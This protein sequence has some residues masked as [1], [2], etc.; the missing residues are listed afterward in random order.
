MDWDICGNGEI[1]LHE[2]G[3]GGSNCSS[4]PIIR[5]KHLYVSFN[6]DGDSI[7]WSINGIELN[8]IPNGITHYDYPF[9]VYFG[10]N[11][12]APDGRPIVSKG[13]T[14]GSSWKTSFSTNNI[15]GSFISVGVDSTN[16]AIY[17]EQRICK[18]NGSYCFPGTTGGKTCVYDVKWGI[19][20]SETFYTVNYNA[21]GGTG[22]PDSQ[23]KSSLGALQ[24]SATV[25]TKS[26]SVQYVGVGTNSYSQRFNNWLCSADGQY[27][28]PSDWYNINSGCTMTAQ[29]GVATFT[30]PALPDSSYVVTYY[31]NGGTGSPATTTLARTKLGYNTSS[32]ATTPTYAVGIAYTTSTNLTLYPIYKNPTLVFTS[33]PKPTKAGYAFT[34]WYLDSALT[35]QVTSN[36][37]ISANTDLYA[38]WKAVPLH[39]FTSTGTWRDIPPKVYQFKNN[40]SW[41]KDRPVYR[42]DGTRWINISE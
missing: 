14:S 30:P 39:Q 35:N 25:P 31:Y 21:N 2:S 27:Y 20:P 1:S 32:S 41:V 15:S 4:K 36:I 38:G 40:N 24:L 34:G 42:F 37:V 18:H 6:R 13:W 9:Y 22:A 26:L 11:G 29:W 12:Q 33:L 10:I 17:V 19:P 16:V 3:V 8:I 28:N 5:L 7:N 23:Q